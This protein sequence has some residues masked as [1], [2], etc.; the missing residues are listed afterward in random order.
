MLSKTLVIHQ[1]PILNEFCIRNDISFSIGDC[2]FYKKKRK[3]E[4]KYFLS[5]EVQTLQMIR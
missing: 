2:Q 5:L 4:Q 3:F 1:A